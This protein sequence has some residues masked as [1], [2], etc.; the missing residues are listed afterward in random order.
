MVNLT[1]YE[2][3]LTRLMSIVGCNSIYF[4]TKE[5]DIQN[6]LSDIPGDKQPFML[7]I[8]PSSKSNGSTQ[9][10]VVDNNYGLIYVL[11]K[12][13]HSHADTFSIQKKLQPIIERVKLKI[14][15]SKEEC[16]IMRG[17]D[18]SSIHTD[19]ESKMFSSVTGWSISFDFST[20]M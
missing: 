14:I 13:E 19:P 11:S 12:E 4:R 15:E 5:S 18:V 1:E 6:I 3:Y 20:D 2:N 17:L 8:I 16:G 10:N 7:V 9:D